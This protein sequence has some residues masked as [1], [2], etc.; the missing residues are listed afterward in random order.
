MSGDGERYCFCKTTPALKGA[1]VG[2]DIPERGG[3]PG[4]CGGWGPTGVPPPPTPGDNWGHLLG[5]F[6]GRFWHFWVILGIFEIG[7]FG[8]VLMFFEAFD[9]FCRF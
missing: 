4:G 6:W 2:G 5:P 3:G 1:W 9:G 7:F 8:V